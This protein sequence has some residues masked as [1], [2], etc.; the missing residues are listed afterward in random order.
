MA[1]S[2]YLWIGIGMLVAVILLA[3]PVQAQAGVCDNAPQTRLAIGGWL[4]VTDVVTGTAAGG[5]RVRAEPRTSAAEV[6]VLPAGTQGRIVD[7]PACNDGFIWWLLFVPSTGVEGWSAEGYAGSYYMTPIAEP[8]VTATPLLGVIATNTPQSAGGGGSVVMATGIPGTGNVSCPEDPLPSYLRQGAAARVADQTRPA[9][10]RAEPQADSLINQLAYQDVTLTVTSG[11]VCADGFTWWLVNTG[12]TTGWTHEAA[13]ARYSIIDP[14]NPPPAIDV[15]SAFSPIPPSPTPYPTMVATFSP[16]ARPT[17][18]PGIYKSA[19]YTPDGAQLV[20]GAGDGL[21]IYEASAYTLQSAL[22]V[23][24]VIDL[25]TI[26]NTL[27]A[28]VWA[29]EG[30]RVINA[31]TGDIRTVLT[32]APH[33][34]AWAKASPNGQWLILGPTSDGATATLWDLNA[35][36]LPGAVPYWWPG[37]GVV[38]AD[39]SPD[40]TYILINDI[41]YRRSC[42]FA[43]MGCQFD[44]MRGDNLGSGLFADTGWSRDSQFMSGF[45]DRFWLW[46]GNALGVG[47][48]FQSTLQAQD[49]RRIALNTDGTR[50]AV[51]ARRLMELWNLADGNY[52]TNKVVEL[53]GSIVDL[54][55]KPDGTQL[56]AVS[57]D[58]VL[59]YEPI[60]GGVLFQVE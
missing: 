53:P 20:V 44:L 59:I 22:P 26:D 45:S 33:D 35:A 8:V 54:E 60:N 19:A 27:H 1:T 6:G 11:P 3:A 29:A 40:N 52:Y 32:L 21:R 43:G 28:V 37:W 57:G 4:A 46:N 49:P 24:P 47:A 10:L 15:V 25:V 56:V 23:G 55:F 41:V 17:T 48:T 38:H 31:L 42:D 34:P 7:G 30:M 58:S 16:T 39:F 14:A 51:V 18:P 5:L 13:N 2:K 12:T 9:R 36:S 50:G